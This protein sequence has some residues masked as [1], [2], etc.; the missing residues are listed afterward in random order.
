[1]KI[2]IILMSFIL[3]SCGGE[4]HVTIDNASKQAKEAPEVIVDSNNN[5]EHLGYD[6]KQCTTQKSCEAVCFENYTKC[7]KVDNICQNTFNICKQHIGEQLK[8]MDFD[9]NLRHDHL[10]YFWYGF[11]IIA[12]IIFTVFICSVF[13]Y[14]CKQ[15]TYNPIGFSEY[16]FATILGIVFCFILICSLSC[17]LF[18]GQYI[19][20]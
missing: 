17:I 19:I 7:D 6:Y 8:Y 3:I 18:A 14:H 9:N 10:K 2:I 11:G 16:F 1:M 20:L 15:D 4:S 12:S 5:K 13:I